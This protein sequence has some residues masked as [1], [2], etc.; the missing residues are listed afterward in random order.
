MFRGIFLT[1]RVVIFIVP[2]FICANMNSNSTKNRRFSTMTIDTKL[3]ELQKKLI[4]NPEPGNETT[5]K[6]LRHFDIYG[7][8]SY[9]SEG[10]R[11]I[12]EGKVGCIVLAGGQGTRLGFAGPKGMFPISPDDNK[13]LFQLFAEKVVAAGKLTNKPLAIAIMTSP[14]NHNQTVD[15]FQQHDF[16]GLTPDQV[17]FFPQTTLPIL[18]EWGE[19]IR[20]HHGEVITGPDGNGSVFEAFV[21]SGLKD[22]WVNQGVRIVNFVP[23]DNPLADPFDSEFVG[24]LNAGEFDLAVKAIFRVDPSERVGVLVERDGKVQVVEYTELSEAEKFARDEKGDLIHR[25]ANITLLALNINKISAVDLPL[26]LAHKAIATPLDPKPLTPNAW[27]F[28]KFIF[29]IFPLIERI[30]VLVYPRNECFAPLK[31]FSGEDS[32]ETV[33]KALRDQSRGK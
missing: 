26:H 4:L 1:F 10:D 31:N 3:L 30:G 14:E 17:D 16:F 23:V 18:D 33:Q 13:T 11:L 32:I 7:E 8:R 21:T 19:L 20:D 5:I 12:N 9:R 6:P 27:K 24:Y 28:E 29:D 2:L 25:C 15:F 22:K